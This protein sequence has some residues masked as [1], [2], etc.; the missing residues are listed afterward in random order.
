M[1]RAWEAVLALAPA[2][3]AR[4]DWETV[5]ASPL[6]PVLRPMA[7]TP[8]N[9]R[10]HGEGDVLAHTRL[11]CERLAEL[12]AW[13]RLPETQRQELFLAALLHDLGK[14]VTTRWEDGAWTSPRHAVRGAGMV[15]QLLWTDFELC[16]TPD[17]Q[18]FRETVCS[19]VRHHMIPARA[20]SLTDPTRKAIAVAAEGRLI[21]HFTNRLLTMLA[22]ADA[23]GRIASDTEAVL[24]R[25]AFY[26]EFALEAGCLDGPYPFVSPAARYAYLTGKS[27][28]PGYEPYDE[29]WGEVVLLSGLPGVGKDTYRAGSLAQLPMVSLDALRRSMGV[30]PL[31]PQGAVAAAAREAAR[32]HLRRREAFV[33]NA[34][35]TT[36]LIRQK[37][38]SLFARY[39]ASTRIVYLETGWAALLGRNAARR[40]S[41][42]E[43]VIRHLLADL[44]PPMDHEAQAV[45]WLC[46]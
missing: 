2:P 32:E 8:Q 45:V 12:P 15:R 41:V 6:R 46:V 7:D 21:P 36:P 37:Q 10:W 1:T 18:A 26:G 39:G 25:V 3:G 38:T 9:P 42:P 14:T 13:R 5:L 16:G 11:V 35:D 23:L 17:K 4:P 31:R 40:E 28:W 19:L 33:W 34:T 22:Q 27:A 29:T 44:I 24:E 43:G 30:D 20:A